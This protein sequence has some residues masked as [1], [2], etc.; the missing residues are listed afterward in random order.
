MGEDCAHA[1]I[2]RSEKGAVTIKDGVVTTVTVEPID[3]VDATGAGDGYAAG[4][5]HAYTQG[6]DTETCVQLGCLVAG[7]IISEV[8]PRADAAALKEKASKAGL[9]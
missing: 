3:M 7:L 2:T 1:T 4:Y 8:G 5:L 6:K 9:L